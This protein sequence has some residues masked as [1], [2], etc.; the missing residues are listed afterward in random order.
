MRTA[1]VSELD[2]ELHERTLR[3][4]ETLCQ[5]DPNQFCC[6]KIG[7]LR[8]MYGILAFD[9]LQ[10]AFLSTCFLA[11]NTFL[12][13]FEQFVDNAG[14]VGGKKQDL[15]VAESAKEDS[16]T[17]PLQHHQFK[18]PVDC[19]DDVEMFP[20]SPHDRDVM[21]ETREVM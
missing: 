8:L 4:P 17:V 13:L 12:A 11:R 20:A 9:Q 21:P 14:Y 15:K 2:K 6:R 7:A 10:G 16:A 19:K 1:F 18:L 3:R 5:Q